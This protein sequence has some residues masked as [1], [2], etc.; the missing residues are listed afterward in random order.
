MPTADSSPLRHSFEAIGTAWTIESG[1]TLEKGLLLDIKE[2]I[3]TFDR[4]WSRFRDDSLISAIARTGGEYPLPP[5]ATPLFEF[6]RTLYELSHG[7]ITPLVGRT[8][9][10]L[11]YDKHYTLTPLGGP[12]PDIPAWDDAFSVRQGTLFA[13][14]PILVDIGAAGKGL[15]VDLVVEHLLLAGHQDVFVD[16]SGDLRRV[17]STGSRERVALENPANPT[18]AIG[19]AEIGS[20]SLAASG[21]NRRRW[22]NN[23]HHVLDGI[24]GLPATG[25]MASFV[26]AEQAMVADGV[27]TALLVA[28]PEPF[29]EAFEIEW[30]TMSDAGVVRSSLNFPGE[31]FS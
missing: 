6:Y 25:V 8:L 31:V 19:V 7:A 27:A 12:P 20:V 23:L 24:T 10:A 2:L 13:P 28:E 17:D 18:R 11:G 5:E 16:A 22:A 15:L 3:E 4:N 9:E 29:E 1:R 30:V 21:T 14:K 26:V